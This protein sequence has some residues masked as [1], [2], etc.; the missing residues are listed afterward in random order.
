MSWLEE[1]AFKTI[2]QV[3]PQYL[4]SSYKVERE[5]APACMLNVL[6]HCL[7]LLTKTL[8]KSVTGSENLRPLLASLIEL[9]ERAERSIRPMLCILEFI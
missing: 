5:V 4:R 8:K 3:L 6:T 2:C 1:S 7:C 9:E